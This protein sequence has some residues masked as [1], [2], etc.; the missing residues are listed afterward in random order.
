MAEIIQRETR[1]TQ[2]QFLKVDRGK[3]AAQEI[4]KEE[5]NKQEIMPGTN[6]KVS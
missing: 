6:C 4:K 3:K 2:Y 5:M 1:V